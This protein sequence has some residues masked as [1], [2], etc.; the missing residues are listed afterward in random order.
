MKNKFF[1]FLSRMKFINRWALMRNTSYESL[2][3]HSHEVAVIA[4]ALAVIGNRR[5]SK[6]Y[7]ADR[8]A[9]IALFHDSSEILTGDM[10]TPVKY[11]NERLKSAY[12]SVETQANEKLLTFLPEDLQGDYRDILLAQ[13]ED[14]ILLVKAADKI[15]ALIK[16]VEEQKMGN[17]DFDYARA[18]IENAINSM[19]L[20]E[21]DIFM[22]EFFDSYSMTVDELSI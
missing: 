12:K 2:S 15:S 1:A 17:R 18:T 13:D 14:L 21:A 16:C 5:L 4:H 8:V 11:N 6:N 7:N 19:N 20:P 10:P 3:V 9:T 22:N